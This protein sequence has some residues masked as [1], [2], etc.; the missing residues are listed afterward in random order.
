MEQL[1]SQLPAVDAVLDAATLDRMGEIVRPVVNL[2]LA[3]TSYG[4]Q[5]LQP[6]IR[7]RWPK[8]HR[9][10]VHSF[11]RLRLIAVRLAKPP[12]RTRHALHASFL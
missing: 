5:V 4:E 9:T 12:R 11:A 8:R 7:R 6:A 1:D 2:N 10:Y 3:D